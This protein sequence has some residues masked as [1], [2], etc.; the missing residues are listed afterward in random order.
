[1]DI[2]DG[3]EGQSSLFDEGGV[4]VI[5]IRPRYAALIEQG[6]KL[7]EFRR[8][9][10]RRVRNGR[11]IFYVTS[12]VQE[13]RLSCAIKDVVPGTTDALWDR[14]GHLSG[15]SRPEFEGYF[16]GVSHGFAV[17]LADVRPLERPVPL[18]DPILR[19]HGYRPPQ[20]VSVLGTHSPVFQLLGAIA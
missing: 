5:S 3:L 10:P 16:R 14:F 18:S 1:V 9:F 7:V 4:V 11:A 20:S 12:P 6:H 15:V 13:F 17:T 2:R 8:Q 19:S